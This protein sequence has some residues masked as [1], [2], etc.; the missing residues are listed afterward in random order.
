MRDRAAIVKYLTRHAEPT[1]SW[2]SELPS[3]SY[4]SAVVIPAFDESAEFVDRLLRIDLD[5]AALLVLVVNAPSD[6]S[7]AALER[8]RRLFQSLLQRSNV[9]HNGRPMQLF[10]APRLGSRALDCLVIS[11]LEPSYALGDKEGVGRARKMG[12]DAALALHVRG[13]IASGYVGFTDA[14][15]TVDLDYFRILAAP[16]AG[17]PCGLSFPYRHRGCGDIEVDRAMRAVEAS[18][19]H[20]VLGLR[21][22][23]SPYAYHSLGSA[24]AVSFR[25]YAQV[26]G[27]PNRQAG[28]DFHLLNKLVKLA[29][30]RRLTEPVVSLQIRRSDRVPFG[31]GP[32][33]NSALVAATDKALQNPAVFDLLRQFLRVMTESVRA[34]KPPPRSATA[35][36]PKWL[37]DEAEVLYRALERPLQQCPTEI[38]RLRRLH[39]QFDA[40][41][42]LQF[43]HRRERAK[44]VA[45][46]DARQALATWGVNWDESETAIDELRDLEQGTQDLV[47]P[48]VSADIEGTH[49]VPRP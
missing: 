10:R 47:G 7:A 18:F 41:A 40:L 5:N 11:A 38:Q 9:S 3:A 49:D 43:I 31:T 4:A 13:D 46:V 34:L 22:A 15:A 44:D 8:T 1:A 27:V 12:A 35:R 28:E 16:H 42:T 33:L 26:R 37:L 45:P 24:L 21:R 14:D 39:E 20:Y 36:Y 2:A 30:L 32:A 48:T 17:D 25:C 19:R 6:A 23:G 29:P